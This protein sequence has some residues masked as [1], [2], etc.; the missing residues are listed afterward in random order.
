MLTGTRHIVLRDVT[1]GCPHDDVAHLDL[2]RVSLQ[3]DGFL[4]DGQLF[5][6]R[7]V[8]RV[9]CIFLLRALGESGAYWQL[10]RVLLLC[11]AQAGDQLLVDRRIGLHAP[12]QRHRVVDDRPFIV[13]RPG[14]ILLAC[15]LVDPGLRQKLGER[16]RPSRDGRTRCG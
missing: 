16:R 2:Q 10:Q 13:Q 1:R 6:L 4:L 15:G 7:S 8:V 3:E 9:V 5:L 12:Q 11:D 14:R